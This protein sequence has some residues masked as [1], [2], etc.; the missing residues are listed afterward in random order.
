MKRTTILASLVLLLAGPV[1]ISATS[2]SAGLGMDFLNYERPYLSTHLAY[3]G[4]LAEN[5]EM[6]LGGTFGI[7]VEDQEPGFFLPLQLGLGFVFP[8]LPGVDGILGVGAS[9]A[10]NWGVG[11]DDFRFY[12]G[13]YLKAGVRVPV[14]PFMRWYLE[15]QQNLHIGPPQW[16]NTS[17]RVMTGI[18][19]HFGN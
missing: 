2:F 8:D 7:V 4:E 17:T 14:H 1:G 5:V 16:I 13:P 9:P 19:F 3:I 10:F 18:N 6:E 11:V 12:L 15:V